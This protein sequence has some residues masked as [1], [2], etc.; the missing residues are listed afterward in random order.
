MNA[1]PK[2]LTSIRLASMT[3]GDSQERMK[4]LTQFVLERD[5]IKHADL[6]DSLR[7]I[8]RRFERYPLRSKVLDLYS[9]RRLILLSNKQTVQ[10]PTLLPAWRVATSSG[11]AAYINVTPFTP[12]AGP[13]AIDVRKLF[14]FMTIGAALVASYDS[15]PKILASS[16]I[17][18][19]GATVYTRMMFKPIDRIT[20]IGMDKL[21]SD[22]VKYVLAKY[23]LINMMHREPSKEVDALA[24]RALNIASSDLALSAFEAQLASQI[25]KK[26]EKSITDKTTDQ[27]QVQ[28]TQAEVYRKDI[29]VFMDALSGT[30]PWLSMLTSRSFLQNF[31]SMYGAASALMMEDLTY[32]LALSASHQCGSEIINSFSYDPVYGV[33]GDNMINEFARLVS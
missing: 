24:R 14:G 25:S 19:N 32:F 31:A 23:Y 13:A 4:A 20:A 15:Y 6:E 10:V 1:T 9:N 29:L 21:R 5:A 26:T 28:I 16:Q 33:Q 11:V 12:S 27:N 7:A 30:A 3:F 17:A 2:S 8:N 18:E 22:Q